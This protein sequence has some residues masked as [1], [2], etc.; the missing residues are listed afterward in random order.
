M[1]AEGQDLD[2]QRLAGK[3]VDDVDNLADQ[4]VAVLF[5]RRADLATRYG[6]E[7]REKCRT[8]HRYHLLYLANA[9]RRGSPA[10]FVDYAVWLK[11]L[12]GGYGVPPQDLIDSLGTIEDLVA[13]IDASLA[14][15][16]QRGYLE[17]ALFQVANTGAAGGF[18]GESKTGEIASRYIQLLIQGQRNLAF[19]LIEDALDAGM[20]LKA[21]YLKVLQPALWEIGRLWQVN[22][23]SVAQEHYVTAAT[24]LL[25]ARLHGRLFEAG[26]ARSL[27][28]PRVIAACCAGEQHE[29]GIRMITDFFE[30]ADWD[31]QYLGGN[32]PTE[33]LVDMLAGPEATVFC[34][35]ATIGYHLDEV[36]EVIQS[37]R[38][39]PSLDNV[40]IMV[41]GRPF[42]VDPGLYLKVGADAHARDAEDAVSIAKGLI[43]RS[44]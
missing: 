12:L 25:M 43:G 7:G 39:R 20:D 26:Q 18:L 22:Q 16:V 19:Q 5:G 6:P 30:L 21:V 38:A 31:T 34:L 33:A 17:P 14:A 44:V 15:T 37:V 10:L 28:R 35:S 41:G 1:T 42:N 24:Q 4:L 9:I 11:T 32:V 3:I 13:E 23:L 27:D 40:R 8:D 2:L 36:A 29:M